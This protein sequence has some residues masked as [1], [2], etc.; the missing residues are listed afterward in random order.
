MGAPSV[1]IGV[2]RTVAVPELSSRAARE[3]V[4]HAL[5]HGGWGGGAV[6]L[7]FLDDAAIAELH[8]RFLGDPTPTDVIAF[9]LGG[10][11]PQ[12]LEAEVGP[13][14]EIYVSVERAREVASRRGA[15]VR[16]ELAL[17]LVHGALHLC[18]FD[19]GAAA[20]RARMRAAEAEV[21]AQLGFPADDA[22]H[23][24]GS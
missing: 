7:V 20:E 8:E 12:Q 13:R 15:P 22:P 16:R 3:I 5:A 10:D 18:G 23:E 19:D 2:H 9:D 6:G 17:Y 4:A 11:E 14:A 21:L 1:R 24:L